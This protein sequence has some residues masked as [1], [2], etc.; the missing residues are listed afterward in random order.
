MSGNWG[1]QLKLTI[2]GES[3]GGG[4]GMVV[5]GLPAGMQVDESAIAFELAR[6][7]PGSDAAATARKEGDV[8]ELLSGVYKGRT[9]GTPIVGLIRNSD[10]RSGD[11]AQHSTL[12]RPSHA[13]YTGFV[14]YAGYNDPRGGGHF[15]GRLTAPLVFA[16]A[17]AR[18]WLAQQ[19]GVTVGAHILRIGR[20]EE[21]AFDA[22]TIEASALEALRQSRFPVLEAGSEERMRAEIM[23]AKA[24]SD[25]VGGIVEC[26]AVGVPAGWGSP[27]FDSVES[28]A[29]SL[30]FSIPAV[31]GVEF[32]GGFALAGMRGSA[33]NDPLRMQEGKVITSTNNSGGIAGGITNG[34]PIVV[35][36]AFKPTP[37]I[38]MEQETVDLTK[39]ENATVTVH[40]RHD[41]CIVVRAVPVVEAALLIALAEC[42][43]EGRGVIHE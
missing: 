11:Y 10:T 39:N 25:S 12:P 20:E 29:G 19:K 16:G 6:R 1:N 34:M 21:R 26:A 33:A 3:H 36:A 14:R 2:F 18:Q 8:V 43:L 37:S 7:A 4:I 22:C 38:G 30:L 17:L 42:A 9:T 15:S 35:R 28:T 41:P 5:D 27:F 31:K 24:L 40:G 13:D 32:G 23:Q